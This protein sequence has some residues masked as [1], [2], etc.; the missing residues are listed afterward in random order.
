MIKLEF[1]KKNAKKR[2]DIVK[3]YREQI[4]KGRQKGKIKAIEDWCTSYLSSVY[5]RAYDF[6]AVIE[7]KPEEIMKIK[8]FLDDNYDVEKIMKKLP[9]SSKYCYI[10]TTLYD[11]MNL[12]AKRKLLDSL[13]VTVCPY[14]N[15]NYIFS[16]EKVRSCVLDHFIP[17]RKYPIFACSFY[18]LIPVCHYCNQKKGEEEF[19]IHP[20][21]CSKS[22]DDLL[23]FSYK[24]LGVDYLSKLE[25][26]EVELDVLDNDYRF[27][28]ELLQLEDLYK[29]HKDVVQEI[30][31]K[32]TIFTDVYMNCLSVEFP[33]L[34]KN[35]DEIKELLYG[36]SFKRDDYG[37]RPLTKLIQDIV[38]E[39]EK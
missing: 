30:L 23:R 20:H 35:Q 13:K 18:N 26:L 4:L 9:H 7:A 19:I 8:T 25:D 21:L 28:A 12:A 16:D 34:F 2:K 29:H 6:N 3:E 27:Q 22:T 17:K 31:K 10:E 37:K 11:K 39:I 38:C 32:H 5:G 15:R 14:C 36:I 1:C 33:W 24:V